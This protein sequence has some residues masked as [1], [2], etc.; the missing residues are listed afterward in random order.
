MRKGHALALTAL[1][2][3]ALAACGSP[4]ETGTGAKAATLASPVAGASP[5]DGAPQEQ[6]DRPRAEH[7]DRH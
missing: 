1:T 3:T 4:A 5:S 7:R 2:I 6:A